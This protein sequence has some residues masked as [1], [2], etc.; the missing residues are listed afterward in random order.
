MKAKEYRALIDEELVIFRE[1]REYKPLRAV[2]E[3]V[4]TA[5]DTYKLTL[6]QRKFKFSNPEF[7]EVEGI[8]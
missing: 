1:K 8:E 7:K 2:A 4:N 5:M 3:A 6:N